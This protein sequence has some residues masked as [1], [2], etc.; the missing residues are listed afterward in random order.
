M[1]SILIPDAIAWVV[2][3]ELVPLT[4]PAQ[5]LLDVL[6]LYSDGGVQPVLTVLTW[7]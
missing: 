3:A 2:D 6:C 4:R 1:Q 7:N 5:S